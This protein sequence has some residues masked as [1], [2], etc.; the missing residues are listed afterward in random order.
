MACK[1]ISRFFAGLK[2]FYTSQHFLTST[3]DHNGPQVSCTS[4]FR[5]NNKNN[6]LIDEAGSLCSTNSVDKEND[7]E[8]QSGRPIQHQIPQSQRGKAK[9]E[10]GQE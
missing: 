5:L 1:S 8:E 3:T 2:S 6:T 7:I 10:P 4:D 9:T